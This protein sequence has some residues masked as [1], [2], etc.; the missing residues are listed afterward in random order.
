MFAICRVN[1]ISG[2][3]K[4]LTEK[5][6]WSRFPNRAFL[7]GSSFDAVDFLHWRFPSSPRAPFFYEVREV[8]PVFG[9]AYEK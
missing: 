7:F 6:G 3:V 5:Q 9:G 1:S 4:Y 2:A 8:R